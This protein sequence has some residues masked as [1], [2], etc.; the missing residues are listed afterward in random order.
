M[1]PLDVLRLTIL[2]SRK[3]GL[4]MMKNL[5]LVHAAHEALRHFSVYMS[6]ADSCS[7]IIIIIMVIFRC[8]FSG[9]LIALS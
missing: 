6:F 5:Y 2:P 1:L 8:Y 7:L 9:E 4:M 3:L